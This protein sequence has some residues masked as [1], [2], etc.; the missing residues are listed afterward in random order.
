MTVYLKVLYS[1]HIIG[2]KNL[3]ACDMIEIL[4]LIIKQNLENYI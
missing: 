4:S 3:P 2:N 1:I